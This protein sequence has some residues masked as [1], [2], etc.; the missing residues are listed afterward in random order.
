[1]PDRNVARLLT[2]LLAL[3]ILHAHA[4]PPAGGMPPA[5][6]KVIQ[7]VPGTLSESAIFP[8]RLRATEQVEVRP[9][10]GGLIDKVAFTDGGMV[11]KGQLLY[12]IDPRPYAAEVARAQASV[13]QAEALLRQASA[14]QARGSALASSQAISREA[15]D[16][17]NA[18]KQ[19]ADA[20]LRAARAALDAA[21][22][23]LEFTRVTA[24][25]SGLISRTQVT[26]GNL[27]NGPG[28]SG[29]TLLATITPIDPLHVYFEV[30]ERSL[31]GFGGTPPTSTPVKLELAG[32][33]GFR[34]PA[35]IDYVAPTFDPATGTRQLRAVL[36][37]PKGQLAPGMF[38]RAELLGV[39]RFDAVSVPTRA[40][41][42]DQGRQYVLVVGA[43]DTV[44]YRPVTLG[45]EI[46]GQRPVLSGLKAG[47]RV[48]VDG[49]QKARPGSKVEPQP[50]E[51]STD[52]AECHP[53]EGTKAVA[54]KAI[55]DC[56]AGGG[57]R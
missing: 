48:I 33:A 37:N 25:I 45:P 27:V 2:L 12:E 7:V 22:L 17:R 54:A 52:S 50:L 20:N 11:K 21:R 34:H 1:M 18:A 19:V 24:P 56:L 47:E 42:A 40:V 6:V 41:G 4:A 8:A 51:P 5:P 38:A 55:D 30:D 43:D 26:V 44:E 57:S 15:I 23:D 46:G 28:G 32:E 9:R 13:A 16:E 35:S 39:R 31:Q 36:P 29:T 14:M 10:V 53:A 49:L 3:P